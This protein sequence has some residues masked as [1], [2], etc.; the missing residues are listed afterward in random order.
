MI[1]RISRVLFASIITALLFGLTGAAYGVDGVILIDQNRAL[2]GNV[3]PGDAPGFPV[4]ISQ[5]GSYRLAGNVTVPAGVNGIQ[6]NADNVTL[7]LNGFTIFGLG[8]GAFTNGVFSV[9]RSMITVM[10]G[11]VR[12]F[13][14]GLLIG[15]GTSHRI[16]RVSAVENGQAGFQL[17]GDYG[18]VVDSIANLTR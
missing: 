13:F 17:D 18:T 2:A 9:F 5:P 12:A 15:G 3:T 4:T 6:I 7:D 16:D 8:A 14:V 1:I 10:N 11:S